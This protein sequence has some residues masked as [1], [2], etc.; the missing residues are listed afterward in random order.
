MMPMHELAIV[1]PNAMDGRHLTFA[2]IQN[3]STEIF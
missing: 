2:Y 1:E 3:K